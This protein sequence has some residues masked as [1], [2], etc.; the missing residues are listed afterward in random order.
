[1][2]FALPAVIGIL[3]ATGFFLLMSVHLLRIIFGFLILSQAANLLLFS[4]GG[5]TAG[6]VPLIPDGA[7]TMP[8]SPE[9]L[10]QALILTAIVIGFAATAFLIVL[11][12]E[13]SIA[14]NT[15]QVD[16]MTE[17]EA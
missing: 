6:K 17:A 11:A 9:P 3:F 10:S 1:M 13:G 15:D 16:Q 4:V 12:R 8:N 5:L 14:M 7:Q 2:G